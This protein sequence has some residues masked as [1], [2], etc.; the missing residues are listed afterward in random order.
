MDNSS[1]TIQRIKDKLSTIL[2][3]IIQYGYYRALP[4]DNGCSFLFV[5]KLPEP[6]FAYE[7]VLVFHLTQ[8]DKRQLINLA[9]AVYL[10]VWLEYDMNA[11]QTINGFSIQRFCALDEEKVNVE[12]DITRS[13]RSRL[14]E[15]ERKYRDMMDLQKE[16]AMREGIQRKEDATP[17]K[18]KKKK[19][20]RIK[21]KSPNG[22]IWY[23]FQ[24]LC[25]LDWIA[26]NSFSFYNLLVYNKKL[27][28]VIGKKDI[29]EPLR[30]AYEFYLR[31][32]TALK[33]ETDDRIYT[34][35]AMMLQKIESTFLHTLALTLALSIEPSPSMTM[36]TAVGI[37]FPFWGRYLY[38]SQYLDEQ[39]LKK[40]KEQ[41]RIIY[42]ELKERDLIGPIPMHDINNDVLS[43]KVLM[44]LITGN[45]VPYSEILG[46]HLVKR[47]LLLEMLSIIN[48]S[49]GFIPSERASWQPTDYSSAAD[50]FRKDYPIIDKHILFDFP[51][52]DEW[53]HNIYS[54]IRHFYEYFQ[55][56]E[57]GILRREAKQRQEA[58]NR[59]KT[60]SKKHKQST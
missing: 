56:G 51:P 14:V 19:L 12:T 18:K 15:A 26:N 16:Q 36:H 27:L 29:N 4:E 59:K 47:G 23:S 10:D 30:E 34:I 35:S 11:K 5:E 24:D 39:D 48:S 21:N 37:T 42:P 22:G 28:T 53:S 58:H 9:T 6:L 3:A 7:N 60:K 2:D 38:R 8:E 44:K 41:Q 31:A 57:L 46:K 25:F 13:Y 40:I 17:L 45:V 33:G 50:F 20:E 54:N 49:P 32:I 55:N 52:P 1:N 43:H